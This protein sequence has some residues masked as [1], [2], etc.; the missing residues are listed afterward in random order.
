[1]R[2]NNFRDC[3]WFP[4]TLHLRS[5]YNFILLSLCKLA[6]RVF[7]API[8][9]I[10]ELL[11][12]G[13]SVSNNTQ[14]VLQTCGHIFL[15]KRSPSPMNGLAATR[16]SILASVSGQTAGHYD[17]PLVPIPWQVRR[18][19]NIDRNRKELPRNRSAACSKWER[20][21]R[22]APQSNLKESDHEKFQGR[23]APRTV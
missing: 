15:S 8:S 21:S 14:C 18:T 22:R 19:D 2:T 9:R 1:M 6:A 16:L 11:V 20:E 4:Q 23:T 5:R 12:C 13:R 17:P 3:P 10:L 7:S